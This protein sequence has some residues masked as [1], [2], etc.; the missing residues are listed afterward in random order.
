MRR[1][2]TQNSELPICLLARQNILD[3]PVLGDTM[4]GAE[5]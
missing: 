2:R 4:T 1:L 3:P 5:I